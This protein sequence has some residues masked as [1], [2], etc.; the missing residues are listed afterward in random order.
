M[1]GRS[2]KMK[3]GRTTSWSSISAWLAILGAVTLAVMAVVP[4]AGAS[5]PAQAMIRVGSAPRIPAGATPLATPAASQTLNLLVMVAPRDPA[6]LAT[7]ATEVST[8]GSPLYHHYLQQGEFATVF[9]PSSATLSAVRSQLRGLGLVPGNTWPDGLAIPVTTT[10]SKAESA[11]RTTLRSYKLSNGQVGFANTTAPLLPASLANSIQSVVGLDTL[12]HLQPLGASAGPAPGSAA[13]TSSGHGQSVALEPAASGPVPCSQAVNTHAYTANLLASAYR[14]N[15]LYQA[16]YTGS[17]QTVALFELSA[18][19]SSDISVYQRCYGISESITNVPEAGGGSIGY[20]T[21]EATS[22]IED[23][24]GLAPNASIRVYEAPNTVAGDLANWGG[25]VNQDAAKVVSTSWGTCEANAAGLGLISGENTLFQQAAAQGQTIVVAAGDTGSEACFNSSQ[26]AVQDP[27]SQPF[28]TGVGGTQLTAVGPPPTENVWNGKFGAGGG[29][30]S[31]RWT[32]PSWQ[33][34]PGVIEPGLSSGGPCSAPA[35]QYCREVPDVSAL[36]SASPGYAF[37]CTAGDCAPNGKPY[38]WGNFLGTSFATPLW[39]AMLADINQSCA[40]PVGFINPAIYKAASSPD[41]NPFNDITVGNNDFTGTNSGDYPAG[42]GYDMASGL[43]TP[44][45][46]LL[47][48]ALG[49]HPTGYRFVASDGGI[50]SFNAPFLGSM[51]G[52]PLNKPIV[53]MAAS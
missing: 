50:F 23:V 12:V 29:G 5:G 43:G 37:Y 4:A 24:A 6:A 36:A 25:I 26:L 16:G 20:G 46:H 48:A 13:R 21:L 18:Y 30:V 38:G 28:V 45:A 27:V 32:M 31:S 9:G 40:T 7:F 3:P 1:I 49:C 2:R 34:G 14:I 10:V 39:A 42:P 15:S 51:G 17:G 8:P 52:K 44:N 22:D 33:K 53:G 35:G 11:F 19:S 47:Q 41:T